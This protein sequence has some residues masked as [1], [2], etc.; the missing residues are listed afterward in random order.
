MSRVASGVVHGGMRGARWGSGMN[1]KAQDIASGSSF[2]RGSSR[3]AGAATRVEKPSE[4]PSEEQSEDRTEIRNFYKRI[5]DALDP[6]GGGSPG[7]P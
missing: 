3:R 2:Y 6:Q 4:E 5:A 7:G 1:T